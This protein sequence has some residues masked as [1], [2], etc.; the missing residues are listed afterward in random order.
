MVLLPAQGMD[1]AAIA[2]VAFT[3]QARVR[4]MLHNFNAGGFSSLYPRHKGGRPPKFTVAQPRQFRKI[5]KSRPAD[6]GLPFPPG[7]W[8]SQTSS[9]WLR[10]GDDISHEDPAGPAARGGRHLPTAETWKPAATL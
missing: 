2:K 7:A 9:W 3:S 10:G 6:H 5:A 4:D 1:V 8:P